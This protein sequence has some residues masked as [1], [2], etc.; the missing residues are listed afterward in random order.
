MSDQAVTNTACLIALEAL[1]R[2]DLL[3]QV[4][5]PLVAPPEVVAEFGSEPTWMVVRHVTDA[6]LLQSLRTQ[7]H[8]GEAAAIAL[9]M[10]SD[11]D[12]V[13]LDDK[14][15]GASHGRWTSA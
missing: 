6:R 3:G 14:K 2:L 10:E 13:I 9:A 8:L 12:W 5:H 11:A 4:F 15:L 1:G 7:V